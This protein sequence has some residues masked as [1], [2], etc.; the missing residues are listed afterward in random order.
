[1]ICL[2]S[3]FEDDHRALCYWMY[4]ITVIQL[5]FSH[6]LMLSHL[7]QISQSGFL[8]VHAD[9]FN[10]KSQAYSLLLHWAYFGAYIFNVVYLICLFLRS[11]TLNTDLNIVTILNHL[12]FINSWGSAQF[13]CAL[14]II[15]IQQWAWLL[16]RKKVTLSWFLYFSVG[17]PNHTY[18]NEQYNGL[19]H[20]D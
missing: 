19:K 16:V 13:C 6:P 15:S 8:L 10:W 14:Y 3:F 17:V 12:T 7:Y 4:V 1:M 5:M 2:A 20:L 18:T 11:N 9:S